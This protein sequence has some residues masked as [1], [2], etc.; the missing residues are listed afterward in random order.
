MFI[1]ACFSSRACFV[2]A[3]AVDL[4]FCTWVP[5]HAL[6]QMT[7]QTKFGPTNVQSGYWL[8]HQG[9]KTEKQKGLLLLN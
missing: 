1:W 2:T 5:L 4:K 3:G 6:G 7:S 8:C 9:A